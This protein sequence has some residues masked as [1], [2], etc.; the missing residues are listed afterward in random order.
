MNTC[1]TLAAGSEIGFF[2]D[3]PEDKGGADWYAGKVTRVCS[4]PTY[5]A[6]VSFVDGKL[7]CACKPEDRGEVWVLL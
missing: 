2:F 1:G 6:D 5:W 4:K 7:W 3:L